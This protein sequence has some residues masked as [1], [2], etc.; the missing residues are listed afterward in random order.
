M[1]VSEDIIMFI[2]ACIIGWYMHNYEDKNPCPS[3]C[4]IQHEH[5]IR[6]N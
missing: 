5:V 1:F 6:K 3:Y 4:E 2:I